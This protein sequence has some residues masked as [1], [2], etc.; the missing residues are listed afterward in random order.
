MTERRP[1][2]ETFSRRVEEA[3]MRCAHEHTAEAREAFARACIEE[4]Q[5]TADYIMKW[6]IGRTP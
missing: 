1:N 4:G 2:V 3:A 6:R 5:A